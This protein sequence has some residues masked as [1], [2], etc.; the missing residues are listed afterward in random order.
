MELSSPGERL[1]HVDSVDHDGKVVLV[2]TAADGSLLQSRTAA[3]CL[4][5]ATS[6]SP[7]MRLTS[8]ILERGDKRLPRPAVNIGYAFDFVSTK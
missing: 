1:T 3:M 6:I 5:G 4:L 2:A 8:M 7:R